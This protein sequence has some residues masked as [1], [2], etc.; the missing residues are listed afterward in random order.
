MHP[1]KPVPCHNGFTGPKNRQHGTERHDITANES[2]YFAS[3]S[4][5][6][7][8]VM[9]PYRTRPD[10][11][12]IGEQP[13]PGPDHMEGNIIAP[14][15]GRRPSTDLRDV[16]LEP[17]FIPGFPFLFWRPPRDEPEQQPK[18]NAD[19]ARASKQA[20]FNA[21]PTAIEA[22]SSATRSEVPN[23]A[24]EEKQSV[25]EE[26]PVRALNAPELPDEKPDE[27]TDTTANAPKSDD[28]PEKNLQGRPDPS[29][30]S[31]ESNRP[32][33]A[34]KLLEHDVKM[35]IKR[36]QKENQPPVPGKD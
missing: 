26:P 12:A 22:S 17:I 31:P 4:Y 29:T 7:E 32:S 6:E 5:S 36:E 25:A 15:G 8:E 34:P 9:R 18:A 35:L 28:L 14:G 2:S 30:G 19:A 13:K 10:R 3:S 23:S 1:E 27:K 33:E 11:D 24:A 16:G 20:L 21:A